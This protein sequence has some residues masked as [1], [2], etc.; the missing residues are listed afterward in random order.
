MRSKKGRA[1]RKSPLAV[2]IG[3]DLTDE[4][5]FRRLKGIGVTI[6]V[7]RRPT[8]AEFFMEGTEE[9]NRFLE[10]ASLFF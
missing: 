4:D 6:K 10:D 7:G 9:V 2:Y 8:R 1:K 5:A 3:G